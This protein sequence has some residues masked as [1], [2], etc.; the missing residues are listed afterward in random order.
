MGI[1]GGGWYEH[2]W[3][4]YGSGLRRPVSDWDES[5]GFQSMREAGRDGKQRSGK[6][7][8][9]TARSVA[10]DTVQDNGIPLLWIAAGGEPEALRISGEV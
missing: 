4:A 9:S 2:E 10:P 8:R 1:G 5:R 6:H 3:R 7:I